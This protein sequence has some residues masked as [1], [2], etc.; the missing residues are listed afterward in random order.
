MGKFWECDM[1]SFRKCYSKL[2]ILLIIL[3]VCLAYSQLSAQKLYQD[4]VYEPLVLRGDVLSSFY[5]VPIHEIFMYAY[6]ETT[7]TWKM[8]PFQIDEMINAQ[9]PF[10]PDNA[11]AR[12]DFY[13]I[14][15]DGLL[16]FRDELVFMIRDL[17][18]EAPENSWIDDE[19]AKNYQRL[20]IVVCDPNDRNN[21]AYGYLYRS[22]T[23]E[24]EI[25]SPYGFAFDNINQIASS[26]Y[27]S[28]R[29]SKQNGLIEDLIIQPPFGAGIDIFD[30]QKLRF[31]GVLDLG[32]ITI[33][34][35]KNGNQAANERDNLHVYNENDVENF[36][37]WYTP[38]P[39]VRLIREVRQTIRFGDFVMDETAFYVKTK[40]Y[41]F[42]GTIGG[43]AD[44]DPETLKDEFHMEEDIYVHLDLLRQ[45]WDFNAAAAGMKF[46]N[47][48]NQDVIV[49][50]N[51]D[52]IL[53]TI[54]TPI[55]EWMLTTGDQG[56]MFSYVEFED[57][58]W[59]SVELYFNDDKSGGQL[60]GTIIQGGDTGDSVSF[61]DQGILFQNH[62]NDSV[63]LKLNFTAYFLQKN[64]EKSDGEKLAYW[65][66]NPVKV[67][68]Q[69]ESYS[70]Q[71]IETVGV[72]H[73]D[74][75]QLHQNYPNPFN[76]STMISFEL[77]EKDFVILR[78]FDINGRLVATLS[79]Q[80]FSTGKHYIQWNGINDQ[81]QPV[82][83]GVYFYEL[84]S[85]NYLSIRKLVLIR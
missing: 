68:S 71:I 29:L 52:N 64:L 74:D 9:D 49:D 39:V 17:G 48:K 66:K 43:G 25:P 46:Y 16:D 69:A 1:K 85:K 51:P 53:K 81:N 59:N 26:K 63:S 22:S 38:K 28:V 7:Q 15:D 4:R 45:S 10:K 67:S 23:I 57:K 58:T 41:P 31:I 76:G 78:I 47:S 13:F 70:T 6:Y 60:D 75:F 35:G 79:K 11:S 5:D 33:A 27:Y 14:Q 32:L 3:M 82:A 18:D 54:D 24:Q 72:N 40:F 8:I 36:H 50:G 62:V 37:L 19:E 73:P 80:V 61:G 77:P 42:N 34:I 83:S 84:R 44:L 20:E 12:Q 65:M 55:K 56:S 21:K 2:L 30:T